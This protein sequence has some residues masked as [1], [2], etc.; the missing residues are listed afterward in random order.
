MISSRKM[1]DFNQDWF[2]DE[3]RRGS[4]L[5]KVML[6]TM[7][8][9]AYLCHIEVEGNDKSKQYNFG[10]LEVL[11]I[12]MRNFCFYMIM[13][14]Y[15]IALFPQNQYVKQY[16]VNPIEAYT[17]A[18]MLILVGGNSLVILYIIRFFIIK[19]LK[20]FPYFHYKY[21]FKPANELKRI[22][23]VI[24][25]KLQVLLVSTYFF[26]FAR[27]T[28]R[29]ITSYARSNALEEMSLAAGISSVRGQL[30]FYLNNRQL[31]KPNLFTRDSYARFSQTFAM[32]HYF[33]FLPNLFWQVVITYFLKL[34][35]SQSMCDRPT[36]CELGD[37]NFDATTGAC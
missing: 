21:L 9:L 2:Q 6:A 3:E 15:I 12:V 19:K 31:L 8:L 35:A 4:L 30:L 11:R 23:C 32:V 25:D 16:L 34:L 5:K 28:F 1:E 18:E 27:R 26:E 33:M 29:E 17:C 37:F 7:K 36:V 13:K 14:V 20:Y 24:R 10:L 22:D